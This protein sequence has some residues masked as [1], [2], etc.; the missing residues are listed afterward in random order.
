MDLFVKVNFIPIPLERSHILPPIAQDVRS[1]HYP[2]KRRLFFHL[3]FWISQQSPITEHKSRVSWEKLVTTKLQHNFSLVSL[4]PIHFPL[5]RAADIRWQEYATQAYGDAEPSTWFVKTA[6]HH[7]AEE[8]HFDGPDMKLHCLVFQK[9]SYFPLGPVSCQKEIINSCSCTLTWRKPQT[10]W[11]LSSPSLTDWAGNVKFVHME[12][13][14]GER[15]FR[16]SS[17]MGPES[18]QAEDDWVFKRL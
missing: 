5:D 12:S 13:K 1:A 2:A 9:W 11:H 17:A 18:G 14:T 10:K 4:A 16:Q 6:P 8:K 3:G 15:S 7:K